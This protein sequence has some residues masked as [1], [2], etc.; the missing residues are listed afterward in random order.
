M[1]V[2]LV[3]GMERGEKR[4]VTAH[5]F[6]VQGLPPHGRKPDKRSY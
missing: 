6:E 3:V 4:N 2:L 5:S 1:V